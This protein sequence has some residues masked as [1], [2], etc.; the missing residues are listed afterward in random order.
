MLLYK[1]KIILLLSLYLA[2]QMCEALEAQSTHH[3]RIQIEFASG[4]GLHDEFQCMVQY[5]I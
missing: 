5:F 4:L 1:R 2:L 3:I